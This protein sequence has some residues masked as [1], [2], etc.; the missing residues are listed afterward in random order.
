M[1]RL[2]LFVWLLLLPDAAVARCAPFNFF[3]SV[4]KF[5]LSCTGGSPSPTRRAFFLDSAPRRFADTGSLPT[6]WRS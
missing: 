1:Q 4:N 6:W 5:P 3:Q 2:L